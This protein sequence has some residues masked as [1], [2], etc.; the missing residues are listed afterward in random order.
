[1]VSKNIILLIHNEVDINSK[2]SS[3]AETVKCP[4]EVSLDE[5]QKSENDFHSIILYR[6][7]HL[8]CF[9]SASNKILISALRSLASNRNG[10]ARWSP[11]Q[12]I[13]SIWFFW[14]RNKIWLLLER[15]ESLQ[16]IR[17]DT[18]AMSFWIVAQYS[19]QRL[20]LPATVCQLR[21]HWTL[22]CVK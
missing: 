5:E 11:S 22:A 21:V 8:W 16:W 19:L 4:N 14:W 7:S 20:Q 10:R 6:E 17:V 18:L 13:L 15:W 3:S 12:W 1:M 9:L 2:C